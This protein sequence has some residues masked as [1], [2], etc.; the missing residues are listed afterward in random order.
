MLHQFVSAALYLSCDS[1]CAISYLSTCYIQDD[2]V[3]LL[4]SFFEENKFSLCYH[5]IHH[6]MIGT[7]FTY[8]SSTLFSYIFT[9]ATLIL[10]HATF[11][12]S[13]GIEQGPALHQAQLQYIQFGLSSAAAQFPAA[14]QN[15]SDL[16]FLQFILNNRLLTKQV[17]H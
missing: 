10:E 11:L 3:S 13:S 1:L 5:D 9:A 7:F 4:E 2:K 6:I 14:F 17:V 16:E 15:Y 12:F 8:S